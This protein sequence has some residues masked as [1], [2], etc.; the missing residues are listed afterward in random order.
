MARQSGFERRDS[1]WRDLA[2][3]G[4]AASL[5]TVLLVAGV[6]LAW[7]VGGG[8]VDT[9]A[10]SSSAPNTPT[11]RAISFA[12][13][14]PA[15]AA[16]TMPIA[17]AAAG[18]SQIV[19]ST[20]GDESPTPQPIATSLAAEPAT[21]SRGPSFKAST[22]EDFLALATDSWSAD[23]SKLVNPGSQ[24]VAE[25]WLTFS[26]V[27]SPNFAVEAEIRVTG[28]LETVCDQSFGLTA[29]SPGAQLV[30]GAGVIYPCGSDTAGARLTDVTNWEDGYNA[31]PA[32]AEKA[33][34]PGDDWQ[35]YRFE[36]RGDRL[37]L[38]VDGIAVVSGAIDPSLA[39]TTTDAEAGLWSQGVGLELRKVT[40]Y[41]LPE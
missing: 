3:A 26:S 38:L 14:T 1:G 23:G 18:G 31:D 33:F 41:P 5:V 8:P 11:P 13:S 2:W 35:T 39:P 24:A 9:P 29:G 30:F 4:V 37:R 19:E 36:L 21:S 27:P 12:R 25:R 40:I 17:T 32:I 22:K 15:P 16:P 6:A 20:A 34:T 10:L 28:V 7:L